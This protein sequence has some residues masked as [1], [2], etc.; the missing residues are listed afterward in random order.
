MQTSR[1]SGD[2]IVEPHTQS[3]I[4]W[5]GLFRLVDGQI[6]FCQVWG[7][8]DNR[9]LLRGNDA[10]RWL[11]SGERGKLQWSV[12]ESSPLSEIFHPVLP[13]GNDSERKEQSSM[14]RTNPYPIVQNN[15]SMHD[16]SLLPQKDVQ[17]SGS[18]SREQGM[19]PGLVLKRTEAGNKA[20][21]FV[22][23][24]RDLR[25]VFALVDGRRTVEEIVR[26]LHKSP[27]SVVHLLNELKAAGLLE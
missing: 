23:S 24:S 19:Q 4:P 17:A 14:N 10:I 11:V 16:M 27:A 5:Q 9:I 7:K 21:G 26:L 20:P 22:L 8:M 13:T 1:Q 2:L 12:E 25:Q 6:T 18:S 3:E 15:P